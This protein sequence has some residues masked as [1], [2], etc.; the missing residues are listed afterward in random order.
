MRV[1]VNGVNGV[2][3]RPLLDGLDIG[4]VGALARGDSTGRTILRWLSSRWHTLKSKHL[5]LPLDVD[6]EDPREAGWSIVFSAA[7][8]SAVREA[9]E[10][11]IAHRRALFGE[12]R[13]KV[14]DYLPGELWRQW[15]AR[16][17][18][19]PGSVQPDRVGYYL[20]LVGDPEQIPYEVEHL[21]NVE[22]AVG[23]LS[24]EHADDYRRY[25]DSVI[26]YEQSKIVPTSRTVAFFATRHPGDL[27]TALSADHLVGPLAESLTAA[28]Q[29]PRRQPTIGR[30][31]GFALH[32]LEGPAAT[33]DNLGG[34]FRPAA[35][36]RTPSLLFTA[37]HG[38]GWPKGHASQE[39]NQGA[40]LCQDWTGPGTMEPTHY[41][42]A[43]DLPAD[44]RVHGLICFHFACYGL[45][46]PRRD[47]FVH[48]PGETP[49]EIATRAFVARLPQ[50]LLAHPQGGALAV[51]GHIERAWGYS[52][53][54][55]SGEA[56]IL[57]FRNAIG[58]VLS[59]RP[60]G[61]ALKDF[62]QRYAALATGLSALLETVGN[63]GIVDDGEI[64][65]TWM[66][67]NDA[68][69]YGLLGD[70]AARLRVEAIA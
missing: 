16:H 52:I 67:R 34:V 62:R 37:G 7:E 12:P 5:G 41:Y 15:L 1:A 22:Y 28:G 4:R 35:G 6:P 27:A 36:A 30:E 11:L 54:D 47:R 23:R 38:V 45:G 66:E 68:E 58:A 33:K 32:R 69:S 8:R 59:G 40:L 42:A 25:T 50:Q 56:Q 55:A 49:P 48:E 10:P 21:L 24:F 60:V 61:F 13:T 9:L 17:R 51:I 44:A 57:P 19:E 46:T 63:G 3:G 70:P 29:V 18:V 65:T 20:L 53:V 31:P 43:A 39:A 64:A 2:N 14:L 26:A